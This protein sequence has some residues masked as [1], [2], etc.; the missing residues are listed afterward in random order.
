MYLGL[1]PLDFN[2]GS[3]NFFLTF[4]GQDEFS[5]DSG[6]QRSVIIYGPVGVNF[7]LALADSSEFLHQVLNP[8]QDVDGNSRPS[9]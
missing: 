1:I 5:S 8:N 3:D 7:K 2:L 4:S 9:I 6:F